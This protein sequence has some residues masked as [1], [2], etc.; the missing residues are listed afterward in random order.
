MGK[1]SVSVGSNLH[2]A[3]AGS[4]QAD[5]STFVSASLERMNAFSQ[6]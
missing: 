2:P 6:K 1:N 3:A 5:P 4:H